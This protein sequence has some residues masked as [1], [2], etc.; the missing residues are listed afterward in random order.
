MFH[1]EMLAKV[2]SGEKTVT[3]RRSSGGR[4]R[5]SEGRSFAIQAGRG[6]PAVGRIRVLSVRSEKLRAIT[7]D[8]ALREG[9]G[10]VDD[11]RDFWESL[12]GPRSWKGTVARIEF[13]LEDAEG[14]V[15]L[16]ITCLRCG[17]PS[18]VDYDLFQRWDGGQLHCADCGFN[19]RAFDQLPDD[20]DT[21]PLIKPTVVS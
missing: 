13:G 20:Y 12:Y 4:I 15:A 19:L 7:E 10:S 8:E 6:M 16:A 3:R 2:L 17:K 14:N 18:V 21:R 11:F 1:P 9:F 5:Y